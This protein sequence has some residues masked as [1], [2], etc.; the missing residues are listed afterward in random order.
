MEAILSSRP[1]FL[2]YR[3]RALELVDQLAATND[4]IER[5]EKNVRV[6][7]EA[8][9]RSP[10]TAATLFDAAVD[11]SRSDAF[12]AIP[13]LRGEA[14]RRYAEAGFPTWSDTF[15][16]LITIAR[17]ELIFGEL[18]SFEEFAVLMIDLLGDE[19]APIL[20]S[21]FFAVLHRPPGWEFNQ[22]L[23]A[24]A[25]DWLGDREAGSKVLAALRDIDER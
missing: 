20:P 18:K 8:Y 12:S 11:M 23:L 1:A 6:P 13:L 3:K 2:A 25:S 22:D 16:S 24:S 10:N 9:K 17:H 19:I 21:V 4:A 15:C 14:I 5:G 7:I